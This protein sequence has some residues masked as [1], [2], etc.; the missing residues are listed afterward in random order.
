MVKIAYHCSHEQFSPKELLRLA[1]K[2]ENA[3]FRHLSSSDHFAPWTKEQGHSGNAWC[4]MG[5]ALAST[6]MTCGVVTSAGYRYHPAL[7]AQMSSTLMEM[8]PKRFSLFMGSGE[9]INEQF[10]GIPWPIKTIRNE[11]L[12]ESVTIIRKL[13]SG[14]EISHKEHITIEKAKLYTIP[15]EKIKIMGA[16]LSPET[17]SYISEFTDGLITAGSFESVKKVI[18]AYNTRTAI[19]KKI[20]VKL[21]LSYAPTK[22][23]AIELGWE[24]W[25]HSLLGSALLSD[26][27]YPK[28]FEEASQFISKKTF[29]KNM[30]IATNASEVKEQVYKFADLGMDQINIHNIN[31]EQDKF[32]ED[33]GKLLKEGNL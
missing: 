10:T 21:D 2:A 22:E 24:Q 14:Q 16:A 20:I 6:N 15:Q 8:Y 9:W 19:E 12:R 33:L 27:R 28:Q 31:K 29:E 17:A 13:L 4:W 32:I 23:Q 3:G 5:A 7:I 11:V 26:L 1:V 25:K 30:I 18:E